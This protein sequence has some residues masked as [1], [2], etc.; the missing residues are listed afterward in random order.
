MRPIDAMSIGAEKT[1]LSIDWLFRWAQKLAIRLEGAR[2]RRNAVPVGTH[3]LYVPS[4][5][6]YRDGLRHGV[7]SVKTPSGRDALHLVTLDYYV[8]GNDYRLVWGAFFV[9]AFREEFELEGGECL[10]KFHSTSTG[11]REKLAV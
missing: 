4:I 1:L 10:A 8:D 2:L 3:V 7:P 6:T 9:F 5:E 11:D